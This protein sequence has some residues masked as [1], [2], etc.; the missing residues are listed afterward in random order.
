MTKNISSYEPSRG[1]KQALEEFEASAMV[2]PKKMNFIELD[3]GS[4]PFIREFVSHYGE[5]SVAIYELTTPHRMMLCVQ[6]GAGLG[7]INILHQ[8]IQYGKPDE[9]YFIEDGD[10]ADRVEICTEICAVW[11]IIEGYHGVRTGIGG[12]E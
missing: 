10:L 5:N 6:R 9:I 2:T 4:E 1:L 11:Q 3:D 12:R 7:A 8:S